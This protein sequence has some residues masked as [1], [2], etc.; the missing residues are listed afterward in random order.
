[1]AERYGDFVS[2]MRRVETWPR[3]RAEAVLKSIFV[4]VDSILA[5]PNDTRCRCVKLEELSGIGLKALQT[6]GFQESDDGDLVLP[7]NVGLPSLQGARTQI[8]T[9]LGAIEADVQAA[10]SSAVNA[11]PQA[12]CAPPAPTSGPVAAAS[13]A[14][15]A[16]QQAAAKIS[17]TTGGGADVAYGGSSSISAWDDTLGP[18]PPSTTPKPRGLQQKEK[19][20]DPSHVVP[21]SVVSAAAAVSRS[22]ANNDGLGLVRQGSRL[23]PGGSVWIAAPVGQTAQSRIAVHLPEN[24]FT[25]IERPWSHFVTRWAAIDVELER[26]FG[27][28]GRPFTMVDLGSCNGWFSLQAAAGYRQ[29]TVLG[30]EGSVGIGNGTTGVEGT[31]DQIIATKAVQTHMHWLNRLQLRNCVVSPDVWD[32]KRICSLAALGSPIADVLLLLSVVHHID[33]VSKQQ[34]EAEGLSHV[35]GFVLLLAKLFD[36]GNRHFVELPDRPWIEHVHDAYN[37][38]RSI[39]EAAAQANGRQWTLVGPLCV[40]DWY[41][42]RELWLVEIADAPRAALPVSGLKSLFPRIL[43]MTV[44]RSG[45]AG[46]GGDDGAIRVT[47]EA[48]TAV[49]ASMPP[50]IAGSDQALLGKRPL[51]AQDIGRAMLAAPTALIA[52]HVQLRDAMVAAETVL[53]G[54]APA[55]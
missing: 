8:L 31:E 12:T 46:I 26:A 17:P 53:R 21:Q 20:N 45:A 29:A 2:V 37:S 48:G 6:L 35:R 30:V 55:V 39:L 28:L 40:S 25:Y 9:L 36:L 19:S 14:A 11:A 43:G 22:A 23:P 16:L 32:Y 27:E 5:N 3:P 44:A 54:V 24:E 38:H 52:A 4:V 15:V 49:G 42:R 18:A 47:S 41:G 33:N 1:M 51:T 7:Q 34:Y 10:Q 13:A 50:F